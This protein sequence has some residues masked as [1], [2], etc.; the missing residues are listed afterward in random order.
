MS[1][2]DNLLETATSPAL[3]AVGFMGGMVV[4]RGVNKLFETDTVSGFLGEE[5]TT[6]FKRFLTPLI[7]T[8]TGIVISNNCAYDSPLKDIANGMTVS[9]AVNV[10]MEL[11]YKKNLMSN[12]GGGLLGGLMGDDDLD[13]FELE[14]EADDNQKALP[15]PKAVAKVSG[16]EADAIQGTENFWLM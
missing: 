7:V 5:T 14:R 6:D 3:Q 4:Q 15:A 2:I 10:G 11:L 13:L 12:L 1:K 8:A 9:G 16:V